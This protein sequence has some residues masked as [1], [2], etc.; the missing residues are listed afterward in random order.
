MTRSSPREQTRQNFFGLRVNMM[1][2]DF[3]IAGFRSTNL[4][5]LFQLSLTTCLFG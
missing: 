1:Q 5:V 3:R 2:S 4:V